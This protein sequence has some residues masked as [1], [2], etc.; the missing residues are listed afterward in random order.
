MKNII[1]ST[2]KINSYIDNNR[3]KIDE[4]LVSLR[5]MKEVDDFLELN[6]V[7]QRDFALNLGYS[8]AFISQLMSGTKKINTSFINKFEK[9]Y[10][11]K[12][13]FQL[14]V[15]KDTNFITKF[16]NSFLEIN[17]NVITLSQTQSTFSL[18]NSPN[19]FLSSE[20]NYLEA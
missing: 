18:E 16:S 1:N 7:N 9:V 2:H 6:N 3:T 14:E 5:L 8:E 17:I 19:D 20:I 12:I 13:N 11:L 4:A 10:N 15:K